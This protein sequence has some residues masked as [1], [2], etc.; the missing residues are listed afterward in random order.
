MAQKIEDQE[1]VIDIN[2]YKIVQN[3]QNSLNTRSFCAKIRL[4]SCKLIPKGPN[5][6]PTG[7]AGVAFPAGI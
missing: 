4:N 5:I 1:K 3:I 2:W 7:G 6:V